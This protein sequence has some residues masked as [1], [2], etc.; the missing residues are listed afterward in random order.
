VCTLHTRELD[1]VHTNYTAAL[2]ARD[3]T[4]RQQGLLEL[5]RVLNLLGD[6]LDTPADENEALS[7][8]ID[9]GDVQSRFTPARFDSLASSALSFEFSQLAP[10]LE[11]MSKPYLV[12]SVLGDKTLNSFQAD[13]VTK[14]PPCAVLVCSANPVN[15]FTTTT[16]LFNASALAGDLLSP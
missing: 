11:P 14:A 10:E 9:A 8:L 1:D 6:V 5:N 3:G 4:S 16:T 13:A 15:L 12:V 2:V 7:P